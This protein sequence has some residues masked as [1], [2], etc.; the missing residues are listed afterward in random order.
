MADEEERLVRV[1]FFCQLDNERH[2]AT[3]DRYQC[4]ECGRTICS[5]CY[6]AQSIV[7]LSRCPFCNGEFE[8]QTSLGQ[9]V[10]SSIPLDD[11]DSASSDRIQQTSLLYDKA[12]A[13]TANGKHS[14]A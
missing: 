10:P 12:I 5:T 1:P 14:E 13:L 9:R 4:R 8:F 11:P 6:E 2:A 7:G 3:E